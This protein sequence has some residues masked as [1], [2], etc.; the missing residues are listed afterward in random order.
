MPRQNIEKSN[1]RPIK[2]SLL[3]SSGSGKTQL[4][5]V[6][7]GKKYHP[8]SFPSM[9]MEVSKF[10]SGLDFEMCT[11]PGEKRYQFM[12]FIQNMIP[13]TVKGSDTNIICIDP[14]VRD[15]YKEAWYYAKEIRKTDTKAPIIIALTQLDKELPWQVSDA[16]IQWLK[17]YHGITGDTIGISATQ[18]EKGIKEL[19]TLALALQ[20]KLRGEKA[21][22]ETT[23]TLKDVLANIEDFYQ[24]AQAGLNELKQQNNKYLKRQHK[25]YAKLPPQLQEPFD[26]VKELIA[27]LQRTKDLAIQLSQVSETTKKN[28]LLTEYQLAVG[29]FVENVNKNVLKVNPPQNIMNVILRLLRAPF[30]GFRMYNDAELKELHRFDQQAHLKEELQNMRANEDHELFTFVA[31]S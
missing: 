31:N 13:S 23:L 5:T 28:T 26:A 29:Y 30:I 3:G 24:L 1:N 8:D 25:L 20:K 6:L 2:I 15:S 14:S 22:F 21:E 11:L 4:C 17:Q 19:R 7:A 9:G 12:G 18:G 16:E 10:Q 27:Q